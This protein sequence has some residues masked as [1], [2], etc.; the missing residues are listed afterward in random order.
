MDIDTNM[1]AIHEAG[2]AVA[3]HRLYP[4]SYAQE[5]TIEPNE[6]MD[7]AGFLFP[8]D[9]ISV[10]Q[11]G[12]ADDVV[13]S[14]IKNRATV[15]C[16]GFAASVLFGWTE[17]DAASICYQDFDQAGELID[18]AKAEALKLLQLGTNTKA[19]RLIADE[20]LEKKTLDAEQVWVLMDVA[21]G[22]TNLAQYKEFLEIRE[23]MRSS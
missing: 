17:D 22:G 21:D 11:E 15:V 19:V 23:A 13:D 8:A 10:F 4:G 3:F 16:A 6:D 14:L 9:D 20:L 5:V 12:I 7:L 2:H 18:Q 1:L